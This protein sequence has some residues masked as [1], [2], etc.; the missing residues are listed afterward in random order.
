M[1][2]T[3]LDENIYIYIYLKSALKRN[4]LDI[5]IGIKI[6][7]FRVSVTIEPGLAL[8]QFLSTN[9]L[10]KFSASR[11]VISICYFSGR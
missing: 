1:G 3:K 11:F 7:F 5:T 6:K 9:C 10:M 2:K 8:V 4:S